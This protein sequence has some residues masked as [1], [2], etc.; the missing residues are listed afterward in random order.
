[1]D[2]FACFRFRQKIRLFVAKHSIILLIY[3]KFG[4]G[5]FHFTQ[6]DGLVF[7][8]NHK[9]YLCTIVRSCAVPGGDKALNTGDAQRFL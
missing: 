3:R 4:N 9:V 7:A 8:V 6:V 1:M 2:G 5:I